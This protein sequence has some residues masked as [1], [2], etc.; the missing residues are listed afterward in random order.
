MKFCSTALLQ[1]SPKFSMSLPLNSAP[2]FQAH[3]K[4][5]LSLSKVNIL[6]LEG[7]GLGKEKGVLVEGHLD[8]RLLVEVVQMGP[9]T[10][11]ALSRAVE[12]LSGLGEAEE[13]VPGGRGV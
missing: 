8:P 9:Q 7:S 2:F 10:V 4:R 13:D 12:G 6:V 3:R 11:E 1:L 5:K